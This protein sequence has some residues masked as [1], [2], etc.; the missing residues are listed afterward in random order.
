M[1][2]FEILHKS[3]TINLSNLLALMSHK[4]HS[5]LLLSFYEFSRY[6]I[7]NGL[8]LRSAP[9]MTV[10]HAAKQLV[11]DINI[12]LTCTPLILSPE[13]ELKAKMKR[14]GACIEASLFL[15]RDGKEQ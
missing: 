7:I 11:V 4:L 8:K 10:V 5:N 14:K 6:L 9:A 13:L 12:K 3:D 15:L 2:L 1:L